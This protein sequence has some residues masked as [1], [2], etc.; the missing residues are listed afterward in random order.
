MLHDVDLTGLW[1]H[2]LT[3]LWLRRVVEVGVGGHSFD[4]GIVQQSRLSLNMLFLEGVD[5]D[6]VGFVFDCVVDGDVSD[7]IGHVRREVGRRSY[8]SVDVGWRIS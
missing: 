2:D 1:L 3:G 6:L 8:W 7:L 4:S 5:V